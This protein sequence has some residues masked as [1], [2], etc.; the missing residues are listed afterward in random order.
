MKKLLESTI[1]MQIGKV[2]SSRDYGWN[3]FCSEACIKTIFEATAGPGPEESLG[4]KDRNG[5]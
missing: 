1:L 5:Q 2:M 4:P 3:D